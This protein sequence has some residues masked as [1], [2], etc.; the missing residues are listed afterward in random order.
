MTY[1]LNWFVNGFVDKSGF[2]YDILYVNAFY[3]SALL[4]LLT[5]FIRVFESFQYMR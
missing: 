1:K 3:N 5:V 2:Q 4:L